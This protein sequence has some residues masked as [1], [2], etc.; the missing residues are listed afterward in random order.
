[1]VGEYCPRKRRE[2]LPIA[3]LRDHDRFLVGHFQEEQ[4]G[5]L[6]YVVTIIDAV[7]AKGM[8]E[9]PEFLDDVTHAA[10]APLICFIRMGRRPWKTLEALPQPPKPVNTGWLSKSS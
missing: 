2:T 7:M 9:A 8:A 6:L 5:E 3:A 10:I 4:L 1:M